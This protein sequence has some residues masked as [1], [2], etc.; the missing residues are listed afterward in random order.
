MIIHSGLVFDSRKASTIFRRLTAFLR[1]ASEPVVNISSRSW[2]RSFS[3]SMA[4]SRF[5]S[6]SA[7]IMAVKL[8]SP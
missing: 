4:E 5:F 7:P 2:T 1:L 8:S 3:R 6:A